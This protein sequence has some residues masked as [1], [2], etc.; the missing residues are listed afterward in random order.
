MPVHK[1]NIPRQSDLQRW[2][3]LKHVNLPEI[4]AGIEL[5]IGTNVSKALE[6]LQVIRSVNNGP[7]AIRTMLGW[8]VNGPLKGDSG[9]AMDCEQPELQVNRVSVV[10]LDE[11]WQQQFK[12][13]FPECSMD[14]QIGMSRDDQKFMELVTNSAKQV[15]G[16]YQINLPL[17]KRDVSMQNNKKII[18]QRALHLNKRLQKDSS[19]HADYMAIMNDLVAKGYA[20]RVPEEDVE[21]SDGKVWYIPHHGIY[22]PTKGKTRVVFD[23]GA[24]FQGTSLNAQL[25]QGP[26]LTSSLIGVVTRFR[27]FV[28]NRVSE[29]RK[30]SHPS[31]WRYV[32]TAS[33]PADVAS[34]GVKVDTFLKNATWVSGPHFLLQP[35]S[36]WPVSPDDALQLP[37]D[38]PEV[39]K[40]VAVNAV[41]VREEVDAVT[42]M[43]HYFDSWTHL[44][45]S[46]AWILRFKTWLLSVCQ[47]RRQLSMALAQSDLDT[48]Q[49]RRSLEK[50]METFKRK[51]VSSCLSVGELEKAELE[52]IKLR[53]RKRF[54]EEFSRLKK[55]KSV[56]GHSHIYT[57]CPLME[58]GVLRVGGRL[59][60]SS[61]PAET[62]HPIILAKDL[63]ISASLLRHIHQEV[64]HGGRNHMLSKLRER[65]WITGAS[66]AIRRVLSKCIICRQLNA[67]PVSQ[68]MADLPL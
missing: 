52:I 12:A 50:D 36:E 10:C 26:D 32:E 45:K 68:Q 30:A 57:L 39:K 47:K 9:D 40:A 13:D 42:R 64:G 3:H 2:P 16:H 7:Y 43:I 20:E 24:R 65:Y 59:S 28:A 49:Q 6:P 4:E 34:R 37:S 41:Q 63:H 66:T 8:T 38:D 33:N 35:E 44:R 27:V 56:K 62:K 53:Q 54:P 15:N 51:T 25:L 48:D 46:V 23:C 19:F 55:G 21:H 18:E 5:L 60:R 1:G 17:R 11:L 22:H 31:Q 29:I 61:M 67:Q 14:E 58:D